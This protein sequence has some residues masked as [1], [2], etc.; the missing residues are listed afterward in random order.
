VSETSLATDLAHWI[1][2]RLADDG[3]GVADVSCEFAGPVPTGN[4]NVTM[5]FTARLT[6]RASGSRSRSLDLVLRMQVPSN[7]IFLDADVQRE[8][9][10]L[11]A[12]D[13][14]GSV[15][16]PSPRWSEPDPAVLDQPFFVMDRVTGTVP[17]GA[18]T[19][20]AAGW[21][22]ERTVEERRVAWESSLAAVAAIGAVDWQACMPFLA[23]GAYG[24][25]LSSRLA[26]VTTW[27]EWV[28]Q[29][30]SYP[31]TDAA[32]AHLVATMPTDTGAPSFVWG[33]A[34][35]GN[36][37]FGADHR[38][39]AVLDWELASLGPA[40]IDLGWWL[41]FDEFTTR[42]HGIAP[43]PGYP[44][45]AETIARYQELTARVVGDPRWYEIYCALVLTVTVIRMA[46]IGVAAGR[47]PADNKMGEGNLTAQMLARWL[48]L[49]VPNLDPHYAARRGLPVQAP[50]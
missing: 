7:Q 46:D 47:L 12:L 14:L 39:S 35:L 9:R 13:S 38:V 22:A 8:F 49:P 34:R 10:V 21:L 23:D 26:H 44:D 11:R 42:A 6:D 50:R 41:A 40:A 37:M 18:P 27:Y 5:P 4:S 20:H 17:T 32:L 15:P 36:L 48:D 43:L 3:I 29:G 19:I 45:R 31:V 16:S 2:E 28:T 24:T 1:G 25:T 30:R 33:D